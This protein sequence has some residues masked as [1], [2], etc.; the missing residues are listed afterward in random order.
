MSV[1]LRAGIF[2]ALVLALVRGA[3]AEDWP[4]FLGP[5]RDG[6]SRETQLT[7]NWPASSPRILWRRPAGAGYASPIVIGERVV[8]FSHHDAKEVVECADARTGRLLW[9]D[10]YDCDFA[11]S[12]GTGP[13]PRATPASDGERVV[14]LGAAGTLECLDLLAGKLK[15]RRH[16]P[17]DYQIPESFFGIG[18]SPLIVGDRVI[19][20]VGCP[21]GA[22]VAAFSLENGTTI[23]SSGNDSA[24]YSSPVYVTLGGRPC[25]LTFSRSGLIGVEADGRQRFFHPFRSRSRASVNAATPLMRGEEILLSAAY[26]TGACLLRVKGDALEVVWQ[27]RDAISAHYDTPVQV[28]GHIYGIDGRQD[29]GDARLV[30]VEWS[31]GRRRWS[32]EGYGCA[33]LLLAAGHLLILREDGYLVWAAPSPA[34]YAEE[35]RGRIGTGLWRAPPALSGGRLFARSETEWV[36]MDLSAQ[37]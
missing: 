30:C 20:P 33:S 18:G 2:G 13:G 7:R 28:D 37:R 36:A 31:T 3:R 10:Q 9:S 11:G 21:A 8:L 25:V 35:S 23:W 5:R 29:L 19:V 26:D 12:Y 34:G 17:K 15:W 16:L 22:A 27:S 14:T 6:S 1:W 32:Q 4:A 24:S